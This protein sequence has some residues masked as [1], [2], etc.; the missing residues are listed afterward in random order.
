[1]LL[2]VA[3]LSDCISAATIWIGGLKGTRLGLRGVG[4]RLGRGGRGVRGGLLG[5][6][7]RLG[8]AEE[9]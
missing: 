8:M 5:A 4:V 1:M 6:F 7:V 2:L 9:G 3:R